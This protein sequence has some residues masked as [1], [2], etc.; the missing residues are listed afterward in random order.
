MIKE[1][2]F[3]LVP[4]I[5]LCLSFIILV[6]YSGIAFAKDALEGRFRLSPITTTKAPIDKIA[7]LNTFPHDPQAYTQGLVSHK[8]YLYESTG[9]YGQ[10]ALR[11]KEMKTGKTLKEVKLSRE[12]FGEGITILGKKIYQLTWQNETSFI[13][14]LETLKKIGQFTY[15]GEGWGL[16]TDGKHLLMSNGSSVITFHDPDSFTITKK[17]HV[18]DGDN[19][20]DGLN[21]L[22][23]IKGEIWANIFMENFVVR[24]APETGEVLGWIDMNALF[25]HLAPNIKID[26]LNGIAYDGKANRIFVTGKLWPA[27]FEIKILTGRQYPSQE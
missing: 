11:K 7:V 20:I 14:E 25:D 9:L 12:Y 4:V 8:G 2:S 1:K 23:F 17:I 15:R 21:E 22:E 10:S 19:H 24:I 3:H 6:S 27:I 16:T 5:I 26:V 18:H 13:Y